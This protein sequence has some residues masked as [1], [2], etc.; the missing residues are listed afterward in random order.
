MSGA[1]AQ[2]AAP[3][4]ELV[5]GHWP[6]PSVLPSAMRALLDELRDDPELAARV[7]ARVWE[8]R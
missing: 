6:T 5:N 4:G 2:G 3:C 1:V 8:T 7:R